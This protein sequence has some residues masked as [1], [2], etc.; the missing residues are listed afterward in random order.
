MTP[1]DV[2]LGIC[3]LVFL[4]F[5]IWVTTWKRDEPEET[6]EEMGDE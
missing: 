5:F 2:G 3:A 1:Y 6:E 4:S